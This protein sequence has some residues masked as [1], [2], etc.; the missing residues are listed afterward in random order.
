MSAAFPA[1]PTPALYIDGSWTE[2]TSGRHDVVLNPATGEAI[3]QVPHAGTEDVD[4]AIAAA[5]RGAEIWRDTPV[6]ARTEILRGAARLVRE[7][8]AE[9]GR[10]MTL[11]QG[12]PLGESRGEAVRVSRALEWDAE[13]ARR[14]YGRVIPGDHD[15]VLSV[16]H[17][18]VGPVAG[19]TPWNFPAGSP[20]RKMAV[21]LSAGCSVVLKASEETPATA[22]ALVQAFHD[23]GLPAGVLNLV[24]GVPAE[25]SAQLIASPVI[26]MIAFTGSIPVGKQ[27]AAAAG[28]AMKPAVMELG[29]HA[30]VIVCD[31]ADPVHAARTAVAAK[32]ANAGQ[33]CTSPSRFYVHESLLEDFTSASSTQPPG[34]PSATVWSR[35][36]AWDRWPTS[37]GSP[38]WNGWSP[39]RSARVPRS[40][41]AAGDRPAP[42][43]SSS[44]RCSPTS[45]RTR[46]S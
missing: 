27:L 14:A 2:G 29:G 22:C 13:D 38:R 30:P 3:G 23:A 12:K 10:V 43:S 6:A 39:T 4:R 40:A 31:D 26:R 20:M 19:F 17:D 16:R 18:P 15:T 11:E 46:R 34:S 25:I 44:R 1:Y 28:A 33:V 45:P 7:R 35:A 42:G 24:F 9:I 32:F 36:S 8:A 41:S 5:A 37:G 21:P